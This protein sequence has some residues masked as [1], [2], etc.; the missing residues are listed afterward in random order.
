MRL[1]EMKEKIKT[2]HKKIIAVI[3]VLVLVLF[4]NCIIA[5]RIV[6]RFTTKLVTDMNFDDLITDK[7][8]DNIRG[9]YFLKKLHIDNAVTNDVSFLENKNFLTDLII[10]RQNSDGIDKTGIDDWSYLSNCKKLKNFE[11]AG[12]C[13]FRNLKDFSGL[14]NLKELCISS[15]IEPDPVI[16]SLDGLQ[17]I[18]ATLTKLELTGIQNETVLNLEKFKSLRSLEVTDSSLREIHVNSY[19]ENLYVANNPNLMAVYLPVHS[20]TPE[21][22]STYNSPYVNIIYE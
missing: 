12:K 4:S 11:V 17:D 22:I 14:K 13:T 9:L 15:E 7:D 1:S 3:C 5:G 18:S 8:V 21:N 19:L 20:G 16:E 6:C 10:I 2:N